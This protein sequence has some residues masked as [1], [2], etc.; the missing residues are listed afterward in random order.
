MHVYVYVLNECYVCT[1]VIYICMYVCMY[2]ELDMYMRVCMH[3]SSV[4][5]S[6]VEKVFVFDYR[7]NDILLLNRFDFE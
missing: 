5:M 4:C 1:C 3:V 2:V 7:K 6:R